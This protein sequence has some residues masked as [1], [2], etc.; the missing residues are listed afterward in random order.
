MADFVSQYWSWYIS[1][2]SVLGILAC[3]WLVLGNRGSKSSGD[4]V[5]TMGH[6]WDEDLQEY[7][8]PLPV[9]WRNMFLITIVWG[10]IYLIL[11]PGLG[12]FPGVLGWTSQGRYEAEMARAK[13]TYGPLYARYAATDLAVLAKDSDAM[14]TAERLYASYCSTCHGSDA[15]GAIGFPNLRDGNWLWGGEPE[16][17]KQTIMNGR[18]AMMPAWQVPLGGAEAVADVAEYV[19]SLSGR[20][21]DSAR[22]ASGKQKFGTFCVACHGATGTGN[23]AMGAPNLIDTAWLYGGSRGAIRNSIGMGRNGRMPAH[24]EFLGEDKVHLLAA[25]VLSLAK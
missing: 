24:G 15:R 11:Y 16:S 17:V 2:P 7:N 3:A 23:P 19:I 14:R 13:E 25:Y 18:V 5:D 20:E 4:S 21:A 1:I 8:N 22:L 6:T 12:S 9:W 10:L